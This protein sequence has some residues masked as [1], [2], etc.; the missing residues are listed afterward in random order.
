VHS[1]TFFDTP[2]IF[3]DTTYYVEVDENGC[4]SGERFPVNITVDDVTPTFDLQ[5]EATICLDQGSV[6]VEATNPSGTYFY[7]WRNE[8]GNMIG[9]AQG[10]PINTGGVYTVIALSDSGCVS[11][12]KTLTVHESELSTFTSENITVDDTTENNKIVIDVESIGIGEYEFSLNDPNGAFTSDPV[13]EQIEPGLHTLYI[14]DVGG[15]GSLSYQ[16][17]VLDYPTFFTP[18]GDGI[19]DVWQLKGINRSFYTVSEI[20]IFNRYGILVATL[21]ESRPS[22]NGISKG[23]R[24]PSNDYWFTVKLTDVNG[25][26][27]ERKGHFS[28]LRR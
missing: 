1:G 11:E 27:I 6:F 25:V 9:S 16:F 24:L 4:S 2:E 18:N 10:I 17:S 8:E 12:P 21:D 14:R 15:C 20:H 28:L 7:Q 5:E 23:W 26:T 22:W 3:E 13:F 19:N